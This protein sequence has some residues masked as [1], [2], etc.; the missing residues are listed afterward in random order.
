MGL[1][2]APSGQHCGCACS[3]PFARTDTALLFVVTRP[4]C[5]THARKRTQSTM[6]T[7]HTFH[8]LWAMR[9]MSVEAPS[10]FTG[11][12]DAATGSSGRTGSARGLCACRR[13][14]TG[15]GAGELRVLIRLYITEAATLLATE[16]GACAHHRQTL[17]RGVPT[18][19]TGH[20]RPVDMCA[21]AEGMAM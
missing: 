9:E 3:L 21:R 7:I 15:A 2:G 16:R 19:V 20:A 13:T 4:A 1:F 8:V 17:C 12:C 18:T 5:Y 11:A 10:F 6:Q 14:L